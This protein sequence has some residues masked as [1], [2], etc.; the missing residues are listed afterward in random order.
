VGNI[1]VL[2]IGLLLAELALLGFLI[3]SYWTVYTKA[4]QPGWAVIVPF[5]NIY[6]L[7]KIAGRPG[8]WLAMFFVPL[9][10]VV[11]A[12]VLMIDLAKAF[13]K[14]GG[15]A[16]LLILFPFVGVPIL[17]WSDARYIGPVAD[18]NFTA[19]GQGYPPAPGY[20]PPPG[21]PAPPHFQASQQHHPGPA[22]A[23]QQPYAQQYPAPQPYP[24]QQPYPQQFPAQPYAGQPYAGQQYPPQQYPP[25]QKPR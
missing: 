2:E 12:I 16:V 22:Y 10:N 21:Y 24:A 15:F 6:V 5:Y 7:I 20:P 18:P 4:G 1:G 11:F 9:A 23:A 14:G 25:P 8:W 13:G 17:A 19:Y 3:A